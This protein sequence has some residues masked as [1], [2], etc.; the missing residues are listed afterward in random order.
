MGPIRKRANGDGEVL[1]KVAV[2]GAG[3]WGTT[4]AKIIADGGTDVVIWSRSKQ[5][6]EEIQF[7]A[8]NRKY[9]PGITL[10]SK[11]SAT[12]NLAKAMDG[13]KQIYVAVPTQSLRLMLISMKPLLKPDTIIVSL[14]KGVEKQTG[15]RPSE[16]ITEELGIA[17]DRVVVVSGPNLAIEIARKEPTAAVVACEDIEL[18]KIVAVTSSNDYF[19]TFL[20]DDVIGTEFGGVLKNLI[21]LAIGIVDGVGYGNN[22]RASIMTRGL[23]EVSAFAVKM[24]AKPETMAGLAGLGDL[25]ATCASPLSRNFRAGQLLGKGHSREEILEIM[26]QTAEG[27]ASVEPILEIAKAHKISMPIVKQINGVISGTLAPERIA[28][29][30]TSDGPRSE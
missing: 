7:D 13:K 17:K 5:I 12:S 26:D 14:M 27:L 6:A 2:I 18:A 30:L 3:S 29:A 19:H 4:F 11:L 9:L 8:Q 10:P 22:T 16:I 25:I 23:A 24:G 28:P 21:A 1:S 15:L 20:N